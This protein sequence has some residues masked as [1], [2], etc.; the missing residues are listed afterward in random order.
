MINNNE[1]TVSVIVPVYKAEKC[2][3][4]C[5]DS[6]L[7]QTYTDFELILVDDGSPDSSGVVCDEYAKKDSRIKVIHKKNSGVS[8]ARNIGIDVSSGEYLLFIDSDDYVESD[9]IENLY[10]NKSDFTCCGTYRRTESSKM[11][12]IVE[13][14]KY[15][16]DS[17]DFAYIF[18]QREIYAPYSKLFKAQIISDYNI[19]FPVGIQWGE[20]GMFIADYLSH[21]NSVRFIEYVGYNY[22]RYTS[23]NTLSSSISTDIVGLIEK[24]RVYCFEKVKDVSPEQYENTRAAIERNLV[25]NMADYVMRILTGNKTSKEK[26]RLLSAFLENEYTQKSVKEKS[27]LYSEIA[28]KSLKSNN[29]GLVILRYNYLCRYLKLKKWFNKKKSNI[30]EFIYI[31]R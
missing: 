10:N 8:V 6:I 16:S 12:D 28:L 2:I 5:V 4:R 25:N 19:R 11:I 14:E 18:L 1:A 21:V 17:V 3:N 31:S 15:F 24:T 13:Y 22:I 26:K 30:N 20:D 9:Y 7:S 29:A 23:Q 27:R